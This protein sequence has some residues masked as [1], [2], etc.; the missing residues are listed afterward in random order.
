M[1]PS[2]RPTLATAVLVVALLF[3]IWFYVQSGLQS[4]G[5]FAQVMYRTGQLM[6]VFFVLVPVAVC[7]YFKINPGRTFALG[8]PSGRYLLAA[9]LLGLTAWVP[10]HALSVAQRSIIPLPA[11]L[12]AS[13]EIMQEA[14]GRTT[15]WMALLLLALV[16]ALCEEFLFRGFLLGGLGTTLR[17]WPTIICAACAFG[18]FHYYL[19]KFPVTAALGVVLGYLCWQSRSI[20]P[21]VVMHALHNGVTVSLA[22]WPRLPQALRVEEGDSAALLPAHLLIPAG[23]VFLVGLSLTRGSQPRSHQEGLVAT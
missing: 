5:D 15:P 14:L 9:V 21:A 4:A 18:V 1:R 20:W 12:E 19:F 16:P 23:I 2:D 8:R 17:K 3:P 10:A 22:V 13:N 11:A 6:P 7:A